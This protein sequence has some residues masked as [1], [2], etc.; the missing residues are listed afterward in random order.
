MPLPQLTRDDLDALNASGEESAKELEEA[1]QAATS[2]EWARRRWEVLLGGEPPDPPE[3][4]ALLNSTRLRSDLS[5][6]RSAKTTY[7][8]SGPIVW[9][10]FGMLAWLQTCCWYVTPLL[11]REDLSEEELSQVGMATAFT[12]GWVCSRAAHANTG[13]IPALRNDQEVAV[14]HRFRQGCEVFVLAHEMGHVAL[15]HRDTTARGAAAHALEFDADDWAFRRMARLAARGSRYWQLGHLLSA[16]AIFFVAEMLVENYAEIENSPTHPPARERLFR[17]LSWA[18]THAPEDARGVEGVM[19]AYDRLIAHVIP[20]APGTLVEVRELRPIFDVM[21]LPFPPEFDSARL[22][23]RDVF[24]ALTTSL[25]LGA[26]EC[27]PTERGPFITAILEL[28]PRMPVVVIEVLSKALSGELF[29]RDHPDRS[30]VRQV[31]Q[32]LVTDLPDRFLKAA[33]VQDWGELPG[34]GER[35]LLGE[36]PPPSQ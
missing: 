6:A 3:F 14:A 21:G 18:R 34:I 12:L 5:L 4:V 20:H 1:R 19:I 9:Y 28:M 8:A 35:P 13:I 30:T 15:D 22:P 33:I 29:P 7:D 10:S 2:G 27:A 31:V 11:V 16:T 26:S 17:L 23:Y 32:Q 24:H 25:L 36:E